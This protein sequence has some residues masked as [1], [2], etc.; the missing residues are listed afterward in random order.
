MEFISRPNA[1][2]SHE[3]HRSIASIILTLFLEAH[4][5]AVF[6]PTPV[7]GPPP[8]FFP[9]SLPPILRFRS[10]TSKSVLIRRD[11]GARRGLLRENPSP[12]STPGKSPSDETLTYP[13]GATEWSIRNKEKKR[14]GNR[15][16][17][18]NERRS[19]E[20]SEINAKIR[21]IMCWLKLQ[22]GSN[23]S[24]RSLQSYFFN[25]F[26]GEFIEIKSKRDVN[27]KNL[28]EILIT[29][30]CL[31]L[32]DET[33]FFLTRSSAEHLIALFRYYTDNFSFFSFPI[34]RQTT[35]QRK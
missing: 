10:A 14:E 31:Q 30:T 21:C 23:I 6:Q 16:I 17:E 9:P 25:F 11:D 26:T 2:V 32:C 34:N 29:K 27:Y 8:S 7:W 33:S 12:P 13:K 19:F 20:T 15:K 1:L 22:T 28:T 4:P 3:R 5:S 18:R 35:L 24:E